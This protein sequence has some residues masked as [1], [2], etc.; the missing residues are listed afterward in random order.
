M[1]TELTGNTSLIP[2][3][4][5]IDIRTLANLKGVTERSIRLN[6]SQFLLNIYVHM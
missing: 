4:I 2:Q 6:I 1:S 5:W 3:D